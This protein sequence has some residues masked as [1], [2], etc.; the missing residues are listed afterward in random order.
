MMSFIDDSFS[1]VSRRCSTE[2]SGFG[3]SPRLLPAGYE[4]SVDTVAL[5]CHHIAIPTLHAQGHSMRKAKRPDSVGFKPNL[6]MEPCPWQPDV[7]L[8]A[9]SWI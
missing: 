6:Q 2:G 7:D 5:P 4:V 9:A 8:E 3:W 1:R